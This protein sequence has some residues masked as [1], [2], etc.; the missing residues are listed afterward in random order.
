MTN[1]SDAPL[2]PRWSFKYFF[3]GEGKQE[4]YD[5]GLG[6]RD[7]VCAMS[8]V[9]NKYAGEPCTV[10]YSHPL[11]A[12]F[13][14]LPRLANEGINGSCCV[15]YFKI[16]GPLRMDWLQTG[17]TKYAGT[18]TVRGYEVEEWIK[19]GASDNHFYC[20]TQQPKASRPV[21][22]MEHKHGVLK[23]WDFDLDSFQPGAPDQH[24]FAPPKDCDAVCEDPKCDHNTE[25][26][27][28]LQ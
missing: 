13:I 23:Q 5:H 19:W 12:T 6:H 11:K 22:Y 14:Y 10:L 2:H 25:S 4:R 24:I 16:L 1:P 3:D 9:S 21:R 27:V 15:C 7:E 8:S 17:G 18:K 28:Q 26:V 20:T